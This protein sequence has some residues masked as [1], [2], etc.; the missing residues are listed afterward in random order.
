MKI[1]RRLKSLAELTDKNDIIADIGCDHA[2]L[3]IYL[4]LNNKV[5]TI[6]AS[7]INE[8]AVKGGITNIKKYHLEDKIKI[9]VSNGIDNIPDNINTLIISGMGTSTIIKILSN[10]KLFQINKLIIESNNDYYMLRKYICSK[11]FYISYENIIYDNK[12]YYINIVF[13]RANKKY[14]YKELKYGPLLL[15]SKYPDY[16]EYLYQKN[17]NILSNIPRYKIKERIKLRNSNILLKKLKR[18]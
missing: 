12:R 3:D 10:P 14:S 2:L 9:E 16:Y 18:K 6:Y 11:G 13:L 4:V 17:M 8:N 7:D 1:S 5:D 15:N